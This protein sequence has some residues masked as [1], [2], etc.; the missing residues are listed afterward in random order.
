MTHAH[1]H[2]GTMHAVRYGEHRVRARRAAHAMHM[3]AIRHDRLTVGGPRVTR[4]FSLARFVALRY[5]PII[6]GRRV[7]MGFCVNQSVRCELCV[8]AETKSGAGSCRCSGPS[9]IRAPLSS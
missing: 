9:Q 3:T 5:G 8:C 7:E 6:A 2:V 1:A 4:A